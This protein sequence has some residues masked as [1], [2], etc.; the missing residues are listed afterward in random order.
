MFQKRW[1]VV[2]LSQ[3]PLDPSPSKGLKV[4]WWNPC[5]SQATGKSQ[6]SQGVMA[7]DKA[8]AFMLEE[9]LIVPEKSRLLG[10]QTLPQT[11][12]PVVIQQTATK[13]LLCSVI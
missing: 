9:T 4:P 11:S 1:R 10:R 6:S 2:L 12:F 7:G 3:A 5:G 13:C 8:V